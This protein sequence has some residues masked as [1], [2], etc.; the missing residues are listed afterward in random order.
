[1]DFY[2]TKKIELVEKYNRVA[3]K[4][5]VFYDGEKKINLVLKNVAMPFGIETF[6]GKYICNLSCD[7]TKSNDLYN[8]INNIKQI[9]KW[10]S[11]SDEFK[12]KTM[13]WSLKNKLMR[14]HVKELIIMKKGVDITLKMIDK[15]QKGCEDLPKNINAYLTLDFIWMN[16]TSYGLNWTLNRIDLLN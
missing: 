6:N 8:V 4:F 14:T 10:V 7:V 15:I 1:M 9:E 5:F 3:T 16:E 2:D 12:G 13:Y 11:E